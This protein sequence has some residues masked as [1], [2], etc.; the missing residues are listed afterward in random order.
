M[1]LIN[2]HYRYDW[3]FLKSVITLGYLGWMAYCIIFVIQKYVKEPLKTPGRRKKSEDAPGL[4]NLI[5]LGVLASMFVMLTLKKSPFQY[6]LYGLCPIF[7]WN[8]VI[9]K[10]SVVFGVLSSIKADLHLGKTVAEIVLYIVG[11]ELLIYSYFQRE[12]LS[13]ILIIAG[14]AWPVILGRSFR[15][16][17]PKLVL[18]WL[19]SC[20]ASSVFTLLPVEKGENI[21]EV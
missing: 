8:E 2:I 9:K 4:W 21:S 15:S 6:Y 17:H 20:W 7:F 1:H 18:F 11:L 12:I 14:I 5:A 16:E 13:Y 3:F 10:R 19:V